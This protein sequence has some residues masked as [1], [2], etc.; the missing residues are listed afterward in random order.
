MAGR[1]GPLPAGASVREATVK[2]SNKYRVKEGF[3]KKI[4]R[5]LKNSGREKYLD[6]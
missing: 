4:Q 1:R 6:L 5:G 2:K 3:M